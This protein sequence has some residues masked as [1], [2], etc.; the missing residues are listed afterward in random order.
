M[1]ALL[2][3]LRWKCDLGRNTEGERMAR[4]S[5]RMEERRNIEASAPSTPSVAPHQND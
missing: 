5:G 3:E 2:K 4:K 1:G